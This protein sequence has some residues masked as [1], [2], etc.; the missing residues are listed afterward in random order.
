MGISEADGMNARAAARGGGMGLQEEAPTLAVMRALAMGE[1]C[2]D[3][4][5]AGEGGRDDNDE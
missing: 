2:G 1:L 5:A 4:Y 3:G